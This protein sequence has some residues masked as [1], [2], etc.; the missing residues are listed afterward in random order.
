V[1]PIVF[2]QAQLKFPDMPLHNYF[3]DNALY[4]A[5]PGRIIPDGYKKCAMLFHSSLPVDDFAESTS[6]KI[7]P[8]GMNCLFVRIHPDVHKPR[9]MALVAVL[10]LLVL[11]TVL[12]TV[13]AKSVRLD[14]YVSRSTTEQVRGRWAMR[15][16]LEKALALL[17]EDTQASDT[18]TDL[19]CENDADCNDIVL[20]G[21]ILSIRIIDE[22]GKLS[23]NTVT[24]K[25]LMQLPMMTEDVAA[26]II[27]WRDK[28]EKP[29]P[30]GAEGGY[31]LNLSP[32]YHIRNGPFQTVRELL[33]V[34]NVSRDLFFG[35]DS[36]LNGRLDRN[37]CDGGDSVP[38][39][40]EDDILDKGWVDYLTCCSSEKN[41]DA[42]GNA[43]VDINEAKEKKLVDS[44][45]IKKSHAKWIVENRDK[46]FE[47][48]A[49]LINK[50]T[51]KD[52]SGNNRNN[53]GNKKDNNNK[54]DKD[55][56]QAEP[57]DLT[58]FKKIAD[59]ITISDDNQLAGRVNINTAPLKVLTALLEGDEALAESIVSHRKTLT[60]GMESVADL[61][62]VKGLSID[63]FKK[64]AH[65]VTVRS[66]VFTVQCQVEID[67]TGGTYNGEA[68]VDRGTSPG[69][70]LYWCESVRFNRI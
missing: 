15:A 35:E 26:A 19:W 48:I 65:H 42:Q 64:I 60:M 31:Y 16:G 37:E 53:R 30:D 63:T 59:K 4:S 18:L 67:S 46:G 22:A 38:M 44:L 68:V 24:K 69:T 8:R 5:L 51:K 28:D 62:N 58:T 34:K 21:C 9:A 27:D 41:V 1:I 70:I 12:V 54:D 40:N 39:D 10:W 33:M 14:S 43:R 6:Q 32:G 20:D 56:D 61:L 57:L 2:I 13:L 52:N 7:T 17:N 36:N 25:Q 29:E 3:I 45:D 55:S 11:L 66:S 47:S 23:I 49:D 50:D